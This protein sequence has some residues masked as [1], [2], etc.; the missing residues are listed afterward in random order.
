M[1]CWN[2]ILDEEILKFNVN[3][4]AMFVLNYEC[5]KDYMISQLRDFYCDIKVECGELIC[6][7][8]DSY[9]KN[10]RALNKNVEDASLEWYVRENIIT[11][12]EFDTYQRIRKRRNDI[13]HELLKNLNKGYIEAD[14]IL[15][16]KMLEIYAKIDKWW[17]NEIEIPI[18]GETIPDDY[19]RDGVCGGQAMVL[20][21]INSIILGQKGS[22]YKE[23]LKEL[24]K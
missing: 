2:N 20:D 16:S 1:D 23:I 9:K 15:F 3:F 11:H 24:N 8:S 4:S 6:K 5:L 19:D 10:V 7:E 21:I 13:T 22:E 12:E 14:A 17:I 18:S